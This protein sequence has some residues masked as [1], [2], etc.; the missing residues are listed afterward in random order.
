VQDL[1]RVG[2]RVDYRRV[3]QLALLLLIS[4]VSQSRSL[5][6]TVLRMEALEFVRSAS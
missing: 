1:E 4:G 2:E 6:P 5:R 3:L